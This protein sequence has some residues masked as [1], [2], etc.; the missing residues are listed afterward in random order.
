MPEIRD[1]NRVVITGGR[2]IE[3]DASFRRRSMPWRPQ[4]LVVAPTTFRLL[5]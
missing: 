4:G 2:S 3:G 1:L 5:S